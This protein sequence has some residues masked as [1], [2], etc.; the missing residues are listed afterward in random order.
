MRRSVG[1]AGVL[2]ALA[3]PAWAGWTAVGAGAGMSSSAASLTAPTTLSASSATSST[4]TLTWSAPSSGPAASGYEVS[5]DGVVVAS[6]GCA[7]A[8]T[9]TST[10]VT[11]A[12]SGLTAGTTYSYSVRSARGLKWLSVSTATATAATTP[13]VNPSVSSPTTASPVLVTKGTTANVTVIGTG[14]ANGISASRVA[15][16]DSAF[17]INSVAFVSSTQVTI[18][19]TVA[20]A[21]NKVDGFR[22]SNP[23]GGSVT[24]ASCL[25]SN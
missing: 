2:I 8:T 13:A 5:R 23:D 9:R 3:S 24:C 1:V 4:L 17:T 10:S 15:G 21:N 18:N 14:F 7:T 11:C 12:D 6:G 25:K 16:G 19:V 20:N 22:L